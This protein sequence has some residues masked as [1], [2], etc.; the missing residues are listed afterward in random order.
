VEE[1]ASE[2]EGKLK[3]GK[4]DVD[5]NPMIA[6]RLNIRSIPTVMV[7]RGGQIVEQI[8]GAVPKRNILEKVQPHLVG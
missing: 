4:V 8:V 1:I 5:A 7:F 6:S 3:V 2:Y